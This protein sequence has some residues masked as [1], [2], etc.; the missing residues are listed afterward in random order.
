METKDFSTWLKKME[1]SHPLVIAGPCSAE[2]EEQVLKIAHQ[3]KETDA[4]VFRAG[5]W[6]PR[7][8]PGN[9][10]GNGVKALPWMA[11]VK[12]ETG[13]LTTVEIANA[14]HAKLALEFDIDI[15]WIGARTTVNPFAVQEIADALRGTD[16]IVLVKNP[17]NPDL[18]LWIGAIERLHTM[19]IENLGAIHRGFSSFKKTKYRNTPQWQIPI[20]LKQRFPTLPIINDPSH[21]CGERTGIFDVCQ[22][23]LDLKF[24]GLMIETHF[25]P[26]NAWS[27]AKQQI[28]PA[29]LKEITEQL[30]V[31]KDRVEEKDSL[32]K[33][34]NLRA[35]INELDKQLIDLLGD[36]MDVV[37]EIGK[38]KKESNVAILQRSRWSEVIQGVIKEGAQHG[39]SQEFIEK[40]FKSIHQESID[41]QEKIIKG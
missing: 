9:F 31:R 17:I 12:K 15:I 6:K 30:K 22:T 25:D 2:T 40:I 29:R 18:E 3:L 8:R 16:K 33:L 28:T 37:K 10:E 21:I 7:T 4:T 11:K 35:Q 24:E 20:A 14:E 41:H 23:S 5:V 26:D 38:V 39:L 34:N 32:E 1:L 19:G 13:M 27:D 36:R